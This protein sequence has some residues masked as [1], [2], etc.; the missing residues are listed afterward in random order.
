MSLQWVR[1]DVGFPRNHKILVLLGMRDGYRSA[2]VFVAGLCYSGEQGT[3]GF[4]P[5]EALPLLHARPPDAARLEQV[6]LW[7][8]DPGGWV[9]HDWKDRQL[10]SVE[11]EQRSNRARAAAAA[12]WH[13]EVL[14]GCPEQCATHSG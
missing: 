14:C 5:R 6:G 8:R 10:S 12:R 9:I 4:I 1:L 3:D 11:H 7:H 13:K 2:V